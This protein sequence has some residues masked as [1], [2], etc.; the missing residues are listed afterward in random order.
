MASKY[1]HPFTLDVRMASR[2]EATQR[3][4][5]PSP[6]PTSSHASQL[7]QDSY[8]PSNTSLHRSCTVTLKH[9]SSLA[10]SIDSTLTGGGPTAIFEELVQVGGRVGGADPRW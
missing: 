5:Q 1:L 7:A 8:R 10:K 9:Q 6:E 2:P 4:A 3:L